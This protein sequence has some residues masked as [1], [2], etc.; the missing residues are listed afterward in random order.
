M[1]YINGL[2]GFVL[3]LLGLIHVPHPM[4]LSWLPYICGAALALITLKSD[5]AIPLARVLA[6][7]TAGLMFFFF[8]GFFVV[9]P[10]LSADWYTEQTGW[11][12]VARLSAAFVML[13][14]LSNYSCRLKAEGR[15]A[16]AH[17]RRTFFSAPNSA[18][19]HTNR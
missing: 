15:E 5:I 4:P 18:T 12:A 2:I 19:Q 1:H 17:E 8:A 7:A 14:I 10:E 16:M 13:P 3:V 11:L 9:A 6:I